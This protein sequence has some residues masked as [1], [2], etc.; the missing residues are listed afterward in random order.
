[1]AEVGIVREGSDKK[2]ATISKIG[3][4]TLIS[5]AKA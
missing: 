4:Y 2:V 3:R 5:G 1:M